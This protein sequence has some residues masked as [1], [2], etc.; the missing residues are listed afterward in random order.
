MDVL[1]KTFARQCMETIDPDG[2]L[3]MADVVRALGAHQPELAALARAFHA[4][5]CHV[6]RST[7]L[8]L[9]SSV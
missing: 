3:P 8:A 6:Y 4:G 5:Y 7:V 9:Q 2:S 1:I